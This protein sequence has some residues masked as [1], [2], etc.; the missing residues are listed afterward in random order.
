MMSFRI[1]STNRPILRQLVALGARD[2]L[3]HSFLPSVCTIPSLASTR[4]IPDE[5]RLR[6]RTP[7]STLTRRTRPR[8]RARHTL[9][10]ARSG[11]PAGGRPG[12]HGSAPQ[13]RARPGRPAE[14]ARGQQLAQAQAGAG[15]CIWHRRQGR[16]REA[17]EEGKPAVRRNFWGAQRWQR[18]GW[19]TEGQTCPLVL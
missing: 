5:A 18:P 15:A 2:G 14:A 6:T 3:R 19:N 17:A 9:G 1:S 10:E 7:A 13:A 16:G 11:C 8:E 12:R 4:E